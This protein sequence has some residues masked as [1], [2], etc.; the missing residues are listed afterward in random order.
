[1]LEEGLHVVG[2]LVEGVTEFRLLR[3]TVAPKVD[4]NRP[5]LV[6]EPH[7]LRLEVPQAGRAAVEKDDRLS[8][9]MVLVIELCAVTLDDWHLIWIVRAFG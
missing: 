9:T 6:R 8:H 4:G 7:Q 5:I 2:V 1:L 3:P